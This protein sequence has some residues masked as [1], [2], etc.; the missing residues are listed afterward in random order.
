MIAY[1]D[2][3]FAEGLV[4]TFPARWQ[5]RLLA[6]HAKTNQQ[7][8]DFD[9]K[10]VSG[11]SPDL[12]KAFDAERI[13]PN[14]PFRAAANATLR[15]LVEKLASL[16]IP[17]DAT[18]S[19]ICIRAEEFAVHSMDFARICLDAESLRTR[20]NAFVLSCGLTPP[21]QETKTVP[22]IARM[23]CPIWWRRGLRR[24]HA[25]AVEGSAIQLGYVNQNRDLYVSDETLKRH[26]Q[27]IKRNR[28]ALENTT[29]VNDEDQEFQLADLVD[30]GIA[31]KSIRRG[32]LMTRI[33][34]F[35]VIARELGHEGLFLTITCPSRMHAFAKVGK[36]VFQNKKYDGTL[37]DDAQAYLTPVRPNFIAKMVTNPRG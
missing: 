36:N 32:E 5:K 19:D 24:L 26:A 27:Q 10:K 21:P 6:F 29:L 34:G 28:L 33:A 1:Q 2:L 15:I 3:K 9:G 17:L 23:T 13:N 14:T 25:K 37:P 4:S 31:N 16:R 11:F 20:M 18:D 22:A 8:L 35:E 30:R 12:Q 7:G